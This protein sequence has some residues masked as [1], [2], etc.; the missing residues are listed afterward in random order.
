LSTSWESPFPE[1][2]M[3][4]LFPLKYPW[5]EFTFDFRLLR[6]RDIVR[7][8]KQNNWSLRK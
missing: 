3:A 1:K 4:K 2:E 8:Y 5:T 6:K 7:R